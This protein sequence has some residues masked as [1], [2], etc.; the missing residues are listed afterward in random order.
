MTETEF[1]GNREVS[2][3][4][5]NGI[6]EGVQEIERARETVAVLVSDE[7]HIAVV[8]IGCSSS[9][10]LWVKFKFSRVKV[11]VVAVYWNNAC[12]ILL[13]YLH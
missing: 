10:I 13:I 11:C 6:I 1:K 12:S 2:R 9:W 3:F 8:D 5:V 4:G 7:F